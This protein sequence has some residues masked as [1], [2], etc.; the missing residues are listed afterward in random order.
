MTK[1]ISTEKEEK[2][3]KDNLMHEGMARQTLA[4]SVTISKSLYSEDDA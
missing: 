4:C 2:E 3:E 1:V